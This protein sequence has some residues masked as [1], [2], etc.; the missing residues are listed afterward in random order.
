[1]GA[2]GR[3]RVGAV[4]ERGPAPRFLGPAGPGRVDPH[5]T[6]LQARLRRPQAADPPPAGREGGRKRQSEA[7]WGARPRG[8]YRD[9]PVPVVPALAGRP[10]KHYCHHALEEVPFW[11][12]SADCTHTLPCTQSYIDNSPTPSSES[13][14][15][16]VLVD[17]LRVDARC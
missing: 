3:G 10:P 16:G 13:W 9:Q 4:P 5:P 2:E 17:T 14:E 12:G 11:G 7:K 8:L 1:M 6:A 15:V